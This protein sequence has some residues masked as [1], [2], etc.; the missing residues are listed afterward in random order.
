MYLDQMYFAQVGKLL[1]ALLP[2]RFRKQFSS[3]IKSGM[4]F[5]ALENNHFFPRFSKL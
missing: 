4:T 5:F 3:G 2:V 1:K